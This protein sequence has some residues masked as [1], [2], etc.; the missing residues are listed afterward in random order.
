M[1]LLIIIINDL[2]D[3]IRYY[4]NDLLG[5]IQKGKEKYFKLLTKLE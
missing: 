4:K 2:A 5:K 1:K 3:K